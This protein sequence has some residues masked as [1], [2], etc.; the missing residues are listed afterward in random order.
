MHELKQDNVAM[1]QHNLKISHELSILKKALN[2]A[3]AEVLA[4]Q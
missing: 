4:H 2:L 1:T 3:N